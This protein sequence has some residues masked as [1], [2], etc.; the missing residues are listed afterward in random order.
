METNRSK[1]NTT[2]KYR[3]INLPNICLVKEGSRD[4]EFQYQY[5]RDGRI[6]EGTKN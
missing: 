2:H 4:F 5:G 6:I 1:N 3:S